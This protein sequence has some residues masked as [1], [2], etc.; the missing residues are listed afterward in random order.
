MATDRKASASP[1]APKFG[2]VTASKPKPPKAP[3]APLSTAAAWRERGNARFKAG[4]YQDA[5]DCYTSSLDIDPTSLSFANRGMA[6]IKMGQFAAAE[7]DC[8]SAIAIDPTYLKALQRRAAARRAMG[9]LM[10]ALDDLEA[11]LELEP[12]NASILAE[13]RA[14][15]EEVVRRE[16][17]A[18]KAADLSLSSTSRLAGNNSIKVVETAMESRAG[19]EEQMTARITRRVAAPC[20]PREVALAR[21]DFSDGGGHGAEDEDEE[22]PEIGTGTSMASFEAA[23][24]TKAGAERASTSAAAPTEAQQTLATHAA[25]MTPGSSSLG[26][27]IATLASRRLQSSSAAAASRPPRTALDF[28]RA[29]RGLKGDRGQQAEYLKLV[30]PVQL[31]GMLKHTLT[32]TLLHDMLMVL[33]E[34]TAG[35]APGEAA[36]MAEALRSVP[37]FDMIAMSL[38]KKQ[39]TELAAAWDGAQRASQAAGEQ[40]AAAQ[41]ELLRCRYKLL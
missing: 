33:L 14:C 23:H 39:R 26:D 32:P 29:W 25:P 20:E 9:D 24:A 7:A 28:E 8:T 38:S 13:K 22:L 17:G 3:T 4:A 2:I 37:R 5:V 18:G 12:G 35:R 19:G 40:D 11:A 21:V 10:S 31:A 16:M 1:F 41:L 36:A 27:D 15:L 34:R 30:S 6:R